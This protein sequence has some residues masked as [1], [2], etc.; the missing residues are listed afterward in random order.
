MAEVLTSEGLTSKGL[1]S[2]RAKVQKVKLSKGL[3]SKDLMSE[4]LT[5]AGLVVADLASMSQKISSPQKNCSVLRFGAISLLTHFQLIHA[6]NE[7]K[8]KLVQTSP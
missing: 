1:I 8:S 4:G 3:T 2:R 7:T 6:Q 5:S